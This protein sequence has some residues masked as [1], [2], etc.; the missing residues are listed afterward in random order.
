[1][2]G[3]IKFSL[4]GLVL[5][6]LLMGQIGENEKRY[7]RV[8]TLQ[9]HFSAYGSERA[10]NNSYYE[11]LIWPADY[12][13]QDNAVIKRSWLA[14]DNFTDDKSQYW[15]KYGL[16][17]SAGYAG[18]GLF[19]MEL[20]QTAKFA[21]PT[22]YVDGNDINSIYLDD[23]DEYDPDLP[24]DRVV[25]NII[26][27]SMGLT[28]ERKIYAFSQQYHDNYF[29]KTYT[30]T[31]TGNT[32]W[33][34]D[35]EL[36]DSLRGVRVG[37]GTRYS[38]GR[39]ASWAIGDGQS[40]GKHT[41]VTRRGEDYAQHAG[42]V[43]T[44]ADGA[45]DWLR[46]G[47]AWAGQSG[48]NAFDNVGGPYISKG[49]RL[50]SPHNV[51]TVVIH[52]D[53]TAINSTDDPNQPTFLGWHAGDTYPS[54]GN[55]QPSDGLSMISLYNMLSGS[56][57]QGKGGTNRF[58]E[59]YGMYSTP[60]TDP[61]T[62]HN[63]EGGTNVMI[64]YGPFN[65]AHG[66]SV[67]I[68]EAEGISGLDRVSCKT[69]G[70]RWKAA[71]DNPSDTGPFTLPNGG[72]TN[73]KD[74]YKDSWVYTGKDSILLTF[75]RA[76]RNY[77]AAFNIPAAPRPPVLFN[78]V[79]G[80]DRISLTWEASPSEDE[81]NFAGYK[82]YRAVGKPDTTY[83]EPIYTGPKGV[84]QF[85]DLSAIRGY[86]YYYYIVSFTDGSMNTSGVANPT[87]SLHSSRF[88]TRTNRA[89]YLRREQ[90][91]RF[92]DIRVVP[93]PY[94]ISAKNSQYIGQPDK[95]MFLNIPG[96][97]R[98]KIFTERGDLI[99]DIDHNDGSGDQEWN[100]NTMYRQ[101]VVSGLYIANFEVT[102][103]LYDQT[104]G[105]LLFHKGESAFKKFVVIR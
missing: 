92:D 78:V 91:K 39:E 19:P 57:Y 105:E 48:N 70:E 22:V 18:S 5:M 93:N 87:G 74:E 86:S 75:S 29:I 98:I 31:N 4:V 6:G 85:D 72:T 53:Q 50:T 60:A 20:K 13:F 59:A 35:I 84:Y 58:D 73:N 40:W 64:A 24:A 12:P 14:C 41:A 28:M 94:H 23:I 25:T 104:S 62:V 44:E 101:V 81:S 47:W 80:G 2:N 103:D 54:V 38:G 95:I 45:V 37:W 102:E 55:L 3:S 30:F 66:E 71:Y 96:K 68:V 9:S 49:G 77:D 21:P 7:I 52:V 56:P 46:A 79:S 65:L 97:C 15:D 51:G 83:G 27:T 16:Y 67:T 61:F 43:L 90:G 69:I 10:W 42:Q 17:L 63:D 99:Q 88:Y 89:A 100:S 32:D 34:S 11:G 8:G 1:M 26:N 76:K 36:T 82:I 33:D